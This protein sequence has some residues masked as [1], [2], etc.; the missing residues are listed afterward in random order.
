MDGVELTELLGR[1]RILE[2][3]IEALRAQE[4][5][6]M[7]IT[8]DLYTV[9]WTDYSAMSTVVGWS[10]FTTKLV[11]Y[12]RI[13]NLVY[14]EFF[15]AGTSNT[16]GVSFTLPYSSNASGLIGEGLVSRAVDNGVAITTACA[17][18]LSASDNIVRCYTNHAL[19]AWTNIGTK[20]V[21]GKGWY[22]AA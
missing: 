12:K 15:I 1:V 19:G 2:D 13:G 14:F 18:E 16:T 20:R 22:E 10:A 11:F 5:M 7:V 9:A 8:G 21:I 6:H 17:W 4:H 3:Q